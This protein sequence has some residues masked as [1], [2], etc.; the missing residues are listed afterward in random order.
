MDKIEGLYEKLRQRYAP[1]TAGLVEDLFR[2]MPADQPRAMF[3][4]EEGKSFDYLQ[5]EAGFLKHDC[6]TLTAFR[7]TRTTEENREMN[8]R[9]VAD[10][11]KM[12]LDFIPVDGC[13]REVREA[14]A[15]HEDSFFVY[16][17]MGNHDSLR[18]F[19]QMFML[20]EK[21]GQDSF[22]YKCA[23]MNRTAFLI[24]TNSDSLEQDGDIKLAGKLYFN[25]PPV[26]PYTN[27]GKGRF[28]F[29]PEPVPERKKPK[30]IEKATT[31]IPKKVRITKKR[32]KKPEAKDIILSMN[33]AV[34]IGR[35]TIGQWVKIT[36]KT[37]THSQL[38]HNASA[39]F[40]EAHLN[41]NKTIR[42]ELKSNLRESVA[43]ACKRG[44]TGKYKD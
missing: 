42:A 19:R 10:M 17:K 28:T 8:K 31:K 21:Y 34:I 1:L 33:G 37:I 41:N 43:D 26:G 30:A 24:S 40:Y 39:I 7:A 4:P 12:E 13:F 11:K 38:T 3:P 27:L 25:L 16:D 15:S 36:N 22:L 29:V 6:A 32:F 35:Y 2:G 9:L 20:S 18:F 5:A 44:I 14:E 23:G